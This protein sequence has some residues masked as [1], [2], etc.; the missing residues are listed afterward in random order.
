MMRLAFT[1]MLLAAATPAAAELQLFGDSFIDAGNANIATG[2]AAA[3]ASQG[4]FQGRF[5]NGPTF[6]DIINQRMTG[7]FTTPFLAGGRNF[8]V[9][10]ARAAGDRV[11]GGFTVP[12][13]PNQA[14]LY[15]A[16]FGP[17]GVSQGPWLLSFGNN[18]VGA[19]LAGDTYGL[20]ASQ[21]G[22]LYAGNM[23][24][25]VNG[26]LQLGAPRVFVFGVPNPLQPEGV[27]LQG[28]LNA[29]L[30]PLQAAYGDRL[31]QFDFFSFFGAMLADPTAFGLPA[32][33]DFTTP[34]L[35]V[36]PVVNGKVDCT[37]YFSFDGIHPTAPVHR[38]IANSFAAQAGLPVP[39]PAT[40]AMMIVGFGLVGAICRRRAVPTTA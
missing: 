23:A 20:S 1:A 29:A 26:L 11:I 10:G 38:A 4:Y 34:C 14:A 8:A 22:D 9:G 18:D 5:T 21:Y 31:V 33:T 27:A 28:K 39:E 36:R 40:W 6:A 24:A 12:G 2:G 35:A 3:P 13:L 25:T 15:G 16:S 30:S 37:G 17:A 7:Q 19:I 32:N